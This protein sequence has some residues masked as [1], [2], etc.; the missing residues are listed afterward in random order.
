MSDQPAPSLKP[1]GKTFWDFLENWLSTPRGVMILAGTVIIIPLLFWLLAHNAAEPGSEVSLGG[2]IK[3]VK[4][5]PTQLHETKKI[6]PTAPGDERLKAR[7]ADLETERASLLA[8]LQSK[9]KLADETSAE[10]DQLRRN[11]TVASACTKDKEAAE[12]SRQALSVCE[13]R[14]LR[15]ENPPSMFI[16][17][18]TSQFSTLP[19][20][21][22]RISSVFGKLLPNRPVKNYENAVGLDYG[23]YFIYAWC[24]DPA[25]AQIVATGPDYSESERITRLMWSYLSSK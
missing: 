6:P 20:C 12:S 23:R 11:R 10:L 8:Q 9:T 22:D 16:F 14:A 5:K 2:V 17:N 21:K 13:Q 24:G 3:Y 4:A 25:R 19:E 1:H 15:A 18:V 7:I